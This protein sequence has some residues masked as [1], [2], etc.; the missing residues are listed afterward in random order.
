MEP[1]LF[2]NILDMIEEAF[3]GRKDMLLLMMVCKPEFDQIRLCAM[4]G[5]K[6]TNC[7]YLPTYENK[8]VAEILAEVKKELSAIRSD[9]ASIDQWDAVAIR[10]SPDGQMQVSFDDDS[11]LDNWD[12]PEL[13]PI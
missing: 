8:K 3:P 4:Q 12:T 10:I 13:L 1:N 5:E 6:Y 7:L 9:Q 11:I 2:Q